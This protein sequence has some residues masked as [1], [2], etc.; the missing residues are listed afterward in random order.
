[1][2]GYI[3]ALRLLRAA[4][5]PLLSLRRGREQT[6]GFTKKTLDELEFLNG[7]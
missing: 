1:M 4:G 6:K 2:R 7:F 5:P 3:A